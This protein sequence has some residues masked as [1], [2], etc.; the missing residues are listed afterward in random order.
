MNCIIKPI[1]QKATGRV[2]AYSAFING[3]MACFGNTQAQCISNAF[4]MCAALIQKQR[5]TEQHVAEQL[6]ALGAEY[7]AMMW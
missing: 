4:V 3:E 5:E 6:E 2:V 7:R 1:V